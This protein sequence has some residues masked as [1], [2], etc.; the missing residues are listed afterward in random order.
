MDDDFNTPDAL[1]VIQS[2][3]R[4]LNAT[5][6]R[7]PAADAAQLA[8]TIRQLGAILGIAQNDPEAWFKKGGT[9]HV[10]DG[11]KALS[12]AQIDAMIARRNAA[13]V[14]KNWKESDRLRDELAAAGVILEDGAKGTTWRRKS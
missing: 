2:L 13:R 3:A 1:A 9:Q 7:G 11:G 5:K 6:T 10:S 8:G 12:D 4:D 14:A